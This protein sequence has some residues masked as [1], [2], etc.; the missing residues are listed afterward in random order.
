MKI[1]PPAPMR[2][3]TLREMFDRKMFLLGI[4][5]PEKVERQWKIE[6]AKFEAA[7]AEMGYR[8]GNQHGGAE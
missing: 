7:L 8:P 3:P 1:T 2:A 4:T 6:L 5:E